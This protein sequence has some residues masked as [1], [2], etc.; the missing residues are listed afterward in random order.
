MDMSRAPANL[1]SPL[2]I[3]HWAASCVGCLD[4]GRKFRRCDDERWQSQHDMLAHDSVKP[5][6]R[7]DHERFTWRTDHLQGSGMCNQELNRLAHGQ[8]PEIFTTE[9]Y[10]SSTAMEILQECRLCS[11]RKTSGGTAK[12]R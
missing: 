3:E 5:Y 7:R 1:H 11:I 6:A 4:I 8:Y 12:S 2:G 10:W 9:P